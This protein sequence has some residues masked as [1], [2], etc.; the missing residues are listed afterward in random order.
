MRKL[1]G[2]DDIFPSDSVSSRSIIVCQNGMALPLLH[3]TDMKS[4]THKAN[5]P[6]RMAY[7]TVSHHFFHH[8]L[9]SSHQIPLLRHKSFSSVMSFEHPHFGQVGAW[10]D[11]L[12]PQSGQLIRGVI[13]VMSLELPHCG[14]ARPLTGIF[15]AQIGQLMRTTIVSL[16]N[17][18]IA[19]R[20]LNATRQEFIEPQNGLFRTLATIYFDAKLRSGPQ[21]GWGHRANLRK[22]V[23]ATHTERRLNNSYTLKV[24]PARCPS[25]FFTY[26]TNPSCY[27]ISHAET[28]YPANL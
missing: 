3:V 7:T 24:V 8:D 10:A 2:R 19:A 25:T 16:F 14:Q 15:E 21:Q 12:A 6:A 23:Y 11:I 1:P 13:S 22:Y 20:P 17:D 28:V 5:R 4:A 26:A 27:C 18:Q 9:I